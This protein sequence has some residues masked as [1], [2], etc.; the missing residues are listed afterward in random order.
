MLTRSQ[1]RWASRHDWFIHDCGD[2]RIRVWDRSVDARGVYAAVSV[3]WA[4]S[5]AALRSWA[6]Y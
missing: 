6:G 4:D 1:V 5:Y 2:G 3:V